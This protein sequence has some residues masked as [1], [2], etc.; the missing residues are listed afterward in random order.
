MGDGGVPL[1]P[2]TGVPLNEAGGRRNWEMR[3]DPVDEKWVAQNRGAGWGESGP[4]IDDPD[5]VRFD[6]TAGH[7]YESGDAHYPGAPE[8]QGLIRHLRPTELAAMSPEWSTRP[9]PRV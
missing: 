1:D 6:P 8:P 3:W 9:A 5:P 7:R 4:P 2:R